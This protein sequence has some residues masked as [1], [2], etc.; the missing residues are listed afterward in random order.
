MNIC[1]S[2]KTEYLDKWIKNSFN[3]PS[4]HHLKTSS[5]QIKSANDIKKQLFLDIKKVLDLDWTGL[6]MLKIQL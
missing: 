1:E 2:V 3:N 5:Q 4:H 6:M